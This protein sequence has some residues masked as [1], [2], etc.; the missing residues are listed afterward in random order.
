MSYDTH[1]IATKNLNKTIKGAFRNYRK[2][3]VMIVDRGYDQ[4]TISLDPEWSGGSKA[5]HTYFRR[6]GERFVMVSRDEAGVTVPRR[7]QAGVVIERYGAVWTET[8]L[9]PGY[10][11]V[12][13]GT[14]MGKPAFMRIIGMRNDVA[15][16][17]QEA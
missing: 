3:Q 2:R 7:T 6:D 17:Y 8:T 5:H 12:E 16:L 13:T 11:C 1:Q 14:F 9:N 15:R 4:P 10:V